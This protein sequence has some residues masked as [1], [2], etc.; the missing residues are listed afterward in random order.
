MSKLIIGRT[1][2]VLGILIG[3]ISWKMTIG[4]VAD[5]TY[6]LIETSEE[7]PTHAWYHAFR[8]AIG[9]L[10][11]IAVILSVFFG[12]AIWRTKQTW[13]IC[14]FLMIGYYAP[15]WIGTPFVPELGA[16]HIMA[17]LVHVLMASLSIAGLFAAR[18]HFIP[19]EK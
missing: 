3:M 13:Y 18:K 8:E 11:A 15:F 16:P 14:L 6:L 10:A 4:H 12:P 19:H 7:G 2:V 5:P 1:L 17:E 9:D